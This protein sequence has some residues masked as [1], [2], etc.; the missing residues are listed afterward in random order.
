MPSNFLIHCALLSR[1]IL[2]SSITAHSRF[3]A[4]CLLPGPT[5]WRRDSRHSTWAF[6]AAS[7]S[8]LRIWP[9][10]IPSS[11]FVLPPDC[12][13]CRRWYFSLDSA[14]TCMSQW[15]SSLASPH[16]PKQRQMSSPN[17]SSRLST[18][19][20]SPS[21]VFCICWSTFF[22]FLLYSDCRPWALLSVPLTVDEAAGLYHVS[23]QHIIFSSA[24]RYFVPPVE[25]GTSRRKSGTR[26]CLFRPASNLDNASP[27]IR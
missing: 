25:H 9:T 23:Q 15:M 20:L 8:L 17:S 4:S 3:F 6:I 1:L 10:R 26:A 24:S 18:G 19:P 16:A 5:W 12:P 27:E 22:A 13:L 7:E 14:R 21:V 2:S 11:C